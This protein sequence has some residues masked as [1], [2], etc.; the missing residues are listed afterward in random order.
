MWNAGGVTTE[1][2]VWM[3]AG[4][5][6]ALIVGWMFERTHIS[7]FVAGIWKDLSGWGAKMIRVE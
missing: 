1:R 2:V 3:L 7:E 4:L 6:L 5:A